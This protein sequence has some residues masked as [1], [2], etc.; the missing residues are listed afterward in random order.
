MPQ[1]MTEKDAY[2]AT[3]ERE[4]QTTLKM[5]K[6]YPR[7]KAELKP[8]EKLK[9]ARELAWM[10]V[11]N[12]MI[13]DA[14]LKGDVQPGG[15]PAAPATLD[16]VIA[17]FESA[18]RDITAKLAASKESDWNATV[19]LPVGP[20]QIGDVRRGDALWMFLYDTIHHR[21][22]LSVYTRIAGA[23]L[24]S[25]YGPTADEPWV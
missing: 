14:V 23:R 10:L 18:H 15:L 2:L 21:G 5:L 13:V 4:Y 9:P 17:A 20:K 12:Q 22:Q 11:M 8:A 19:K 6:G 3:F 1:T 24:G 16:A 7:D 25:I